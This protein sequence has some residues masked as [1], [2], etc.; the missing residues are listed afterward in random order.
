MLCYQKDPARVMLNHRH[1]LKTRYF[2]YYHHLQA[3]KNA[4]NDIDHF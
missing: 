1:G 4:G 2:F 3:V